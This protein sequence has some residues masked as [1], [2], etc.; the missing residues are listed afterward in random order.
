M[1]RPAKPWGLPLSSFLLFHHLP[2][3]TPIKPCLTDP[4]VNQSY[5]YLYVHALTTGQR[6]SATMIALENELLTNQLQ[7]EN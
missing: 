3:L 4:H 6:L 1:A 2:L 7:K 5:V